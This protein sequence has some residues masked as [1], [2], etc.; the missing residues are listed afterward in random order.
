MSESSADAWGRRRL[1]EIAISE[2]DR[3]THETARD[4]ENFRTGIKA[5]VAVVEE[6]WA[7]SGSSDGRRGFDV[8]KPK[9]L[10]TVR[11]LRSFLDD[12]ELAD[13]DDDEVLVA[14]ITGHGV[15]RDS[16][17]HF[18]LLPDSDR[19]RVLNT[20]FQTADLVTTLLDSRATHVLVMVDSCFSGVLRR[21]LDRR[22]AA[23]GDERRGL[24]SLVVL[25][26]ADEF[27]SPRLEVF[28]RLLKATMTHLGE[29]SA[30]YALPYLSYEDFFTAMKK[31]YV[32]PLMA[33]VHRVWPAESLQRDKEHQEPSPCLPNPGYTAKPDVVEPA[34][35]AVAWSPADRDSY[36]LSRAS[37][38]PSP[39][40]GVTGWYFTG[41]TA[42]MR[43]VTE[44]LAGDEGTLV[45][46]GE[47]GSG[48]SALLA[49][50]VTLSDARF[51]SDET[52]RQVVEAT[53]PDLLVPV[54]AIDAAVLARNADT[55]ELTAALYEALTGRLP[56]RGAG[57]RTVDL[58]LDHAREHLRRQG[59]ALT[60]V[61]DGIDEARNPT[62]TITDLIR[63][64]SEQWS[65]DGRPAV[66]MLLGIRSAHAPAAGRLQPSRDRASD[67]LNLLVRSTESGEPLRTDTGAATDVAAY[68][69]TLLRALF[70]VHDD[71]VHADIQLLDELA[72][73]VAEEVAPSFLDARLAAE[74]LKRGSSLPAPDD[75]EWRASLRQGTQLLLLRDL[76]EVSRNTD[77]PAEAVIQ[78]LRATALARGAGLPWA[79]VWPCAVAALTTEGHPAPADSLIRQVRESRLAGYLTTAVEDGRFVYRPIHERVGELL[80]NTPHLLLVESLTSTHMLPAQANVGEDHRRLAVAFSSLRQEANYGPPHPYLRHHLVEHAAAGEVLNDSVV[81]EKFLPYETSGN[82][83]GA[84]GLLSEHT[85]DTTR[86]FA[87]TRIEPF[88]GDAPP[89]ARAESLRFSLWEH[90]DGRCA[91][92]SATGRPE[93]E[94]SA[95]LQPRWKDLAVQ[96]NVLAR[97]EAPVHSLVSFGLRDGTPLVA[98]GCGDGTVRVWDPSTVTPLGPPIHVP[99]GAVRASAV[100]PGPDG[101]PW[102][103]LGTDDGV[104]ACDPLSGEVVDLP[105]RE[106]VL[107]M[108]SYTDEDGR[109]LLAVGTAEGLALYDTAG[110]RQAAD[111]LVRRILVGPVT[112]LAALERPGK[113]ALLA[114]QG[115]DSAEVRDGSSLRTLCR[116]PVPGRDVSALSLVGGRNDE[117]LLAVATRARGGAVLFWEAVSGEARPHSTIRRGASVLTTCRQDDSRGRTLLALGGDDGSVQLWDPATG[118]ESCRFP[119][120]H[121]G[122]IRGL[123]VVPG[124]EGVQVLVSG[125]ADRTVRVWNPEVWQRR[126]VSR[127]GPRAVAGGQFALSPHGDGGPHVLV[128]AGPDRNLILRSA[129]S[130]EVLDTI[131]LP[132]RAAAE[133]PVTA[134]ATYRAPDGSTA[135]VVGLPDGSV[136]RWNGTWLPLNVWT[137]AEDRPTAFAVFPHEGRTVLAVGTSSGSIAYCD[138]DT[139]SALGWRHGGGTGGPIHA[140]VHLPLRA[141]GVLAVATG[142]EV[143]LCRPL[144]VPHH[145]LPASMG[146]VTSLAVLPGEDEADGHLVAGG[147]DGRIHVCSPDTSGPAAFTLPVSHDGPV[148]ALCVVRSP[149]VRPLIVST[150]LSDTTLRLWDAGTGEEVLRLVTAASLTSLGIVP[151]GEGG[152]RPSPPLIVFGGPAGAAAVALLPSSM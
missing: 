95:P 85:P 7:A 152:G 151:P 107:C 123:T 64:L 80:R 127:R 35:S 36:W 145:E 142:E 37:G 81:T 26:S 108:T 143:L 104:Q 99:G 22:L 29:E 117:A 61:V 14:Y 132:H 100:V 50:A 83:R 67:L 38:R 51:R 60:V 128:S 40:A 42:Q 77:L 75:P 122:G 144:R 63:P 13:A 97:Q 133:G 59:R 87:W 4:H 8:V 73:A 88:L 1:V 34:R 27:E 52:Y 15:S 146:P 68:T 11:D 41:R 32:H 66:R 119:T 48:K 113:L 74:A 106:P 86:L 96:G 33:N 49:R 2:Y 114:V 112:A 57:I 58:I 103:A 136:A 30:G 23:L 12:E 71:A 125:S 3:D 43:R 131:A 147:A 39:T 90:E 5:Q 89:P 9:D 91:H 10:R 25:T 17:I 140:L 120:D 21:D 44:F 124:P 56:E 62:R 92:T 130:G 101:Q 141:G 129:E 24:N 139:G 105:V 20:A 121:T 84:L 116:V 45:V 76:E 16:E 135:V 98:V 55:D 31:V 110:I 70:G 148:S 19:E 134:L 6:W 18:L 53:A 93:P 111:D 115:T 54:G 65:D 28:S 118:E 72:A 82:V 47:A 138:T 109:V 126:A 79:E 137:S 149:D 94:T 102:L 78:V 46:T 150:G 69:S